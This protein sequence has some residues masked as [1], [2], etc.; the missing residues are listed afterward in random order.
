MQ[1]IMVHAITLAA[2]VGLMATLACS[3]GSEAQRI[4]DPVPL[5]RSG[6]SGSTYTPIS[7][8]ATP[9]LAAQAEGRNSET[10][11]APMTP[12]ST[13]L[14]PIAMD[15]TTLAPVASSCRQVRQQTPVPTSRPADTPSGSYKHTSAYAIRYRN[16]RT[17][18]HGYPD[19]DEHS[20]SHTDGC[21]SGCA[22]TNTGDP[23]NRKHSSVQRWH[24]FSG[25]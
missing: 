8:T 22:Q 1:K 6:E 16:S 3:R 21:G 9:T 20:G 25:R 15:T 7:A 11:T 2:L 4:S 23:H 5:A 19:A 24:R 10:P 18:G 12:T 14:A 13:A 17:D